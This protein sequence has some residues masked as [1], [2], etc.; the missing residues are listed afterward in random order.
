MITL[1]NENNLMGF[2]LLSLYYESYIRIQIDVQ[3]L[4]EILNQDLSSIRRYLIDLHLPNIQNAN[5]IQPLLPI[6]SSK[7]K[8]LLSPNNTSS[9]PLPPNRSFIDFYWM[10]PFHVFS[11]EN[12]E[13]I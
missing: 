10:G 13:V 12:K 9:V 1:S 5:V 4:S 7:D 6:K 2:N 3:D 8:E 11:V